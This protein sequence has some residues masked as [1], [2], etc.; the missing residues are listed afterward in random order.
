MTKI[1]PYLSFWTYGGIF[2]ENE[3][4]LDAHGKNHFILNMY[5]VCAYLL[6]RL[7]GEVHL[8][9]DKRGAKFLK[10]IPF[11][12]VDT[13]LENL[14]KDIG[15]LWSAGKIYSY[16]L[17]A[18]K[19]ELFAHI[20][21]D[22]FMTKKLPEDLVNSDVFSG[23]KEFNVFFRYG[24]KEFFDVI[25][26]KYLLAEKLP[27]TSYSMCIF[28]G[29]DFDFIKYYSEIAL[30]AIL[31]KENIKAIKNHYFEAYHYPACITEQYFLTI[32]SEVKGK[33]I[34]V[35]INNLDEQSDHD[36]IQK[37]GLP[38]EYLHLCQSK[39]DENIREFV[40][41]TGN[42]IFNQKKI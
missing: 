29:R 41:K 30:K 9:T 12:T 34:K 15:I 20:D 7:Y 16:K 18:D 8:I 42:M 6:L 4:V 26:N 31:D 35:L 24:V 36:S 38:F 27:D 22:V 21:A 2:T 10:D 23:H 5:K 32:A 1:K 33:N 11:T 28:G 3:K 14:P 25:P 39:H 13:S 19:K 17:L 40:I 37:K